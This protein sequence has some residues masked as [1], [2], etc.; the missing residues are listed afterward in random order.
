MGLRTSRV[1][2]QVQTRVATD[3]RYQT[4][5]PTIDRM[6]ALAWLPIALLAA[7][8]VALAYLL[9]TSGI[10]TTSYDIQRLNVERSEWRLRNEQL[11]LEIAKRRSL[12]WVEAEAVGRLG[13]VPA[14]NPIYLPMDSNTFDA[15]PLGG[16]VTLSRNGPR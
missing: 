12:T 11:R 15:L 9:Q 6:R 8:A 10:A 5:A 14:E 13:M 3:E 16:A 1:I 7:S 4:V 2:Q